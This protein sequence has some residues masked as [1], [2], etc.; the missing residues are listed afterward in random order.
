M[1]GK[2]K[3]IPVTLSVHNILEPFLTLTFLCCRGLL[4]HC[5]MELMKCFYYCG[6]LTHEA[7]KIKKI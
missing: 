3:H 5:R 2:M 6:N 4:Y 7:R 1:E